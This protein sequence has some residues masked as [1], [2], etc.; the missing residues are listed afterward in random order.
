MTN[1]TRPC[2]TRFVASRPRK[3]GRGRFPSY[4]SSCYY[5]PCLTQTSRMTTPGPPSCPCAK[6]RV[7]A[8]TM[9]LLFCWRRLAT[10][11]GAWALCQEQPQRVRCALWSLNSPCSCSARTRNRASHQATRT[12]ESR[13]SVTRLRSKRRS[14]LLSRVPRGAKVQGSK[15]AIRFGES[16]PPRTTRK[17]VSG[18][19]CVRT[20]M[21]RIVR[22]LV[23]V[24]LV[25]SS[26]VFD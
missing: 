23:L 22:W 16:S 2:L 17:P 8:W 26:R 11:A 18:I 21:L 9:C 5:Y 20:V 10:T 1:L 7:V 19:F 13:F 14:S 24:R 4:E 25:S 6:A 15:M 12:P 3:P